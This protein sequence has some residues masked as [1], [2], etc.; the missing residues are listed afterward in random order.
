M[1]I[2][3]SAKDDVP[4]PPSRDRRRGLSDLSAA[5]VKVAHAINYLAT[6]Q[7][8]GRRD[9]VQANRKAMAILCDAF[10][11]LAVMERRVPEQ[12][13]LLRRLWEFTRGSDI[14]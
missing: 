13:S 4:L 6:E 12:R 9:P 10:E 3:T 8:A 1:E 7:L 2:P 5:A 11:Q 14:S